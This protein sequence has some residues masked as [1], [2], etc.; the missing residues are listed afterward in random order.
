MR[1]Y[2]ESSVLSAL[3]P[4][5]YLKDVRVAEEGNLY[6]LH[7]TGTDA[8]ANALC[9]SIYESLQ[10]G[11]LDSFAESFSTEVIAGYLTIDR[12][13]GLPVKAGMAVTRTHIIGGIYYKLT[14]KLD[15]DITLASET[16]YDTIMEK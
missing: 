10:S 13:T 11:N 5:A 6:T 9:A 3:F 7:F 15:S 16:A 12:F 2:C 8:L 14:Y 1:S 4:F